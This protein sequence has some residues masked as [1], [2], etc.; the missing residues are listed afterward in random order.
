MFKRLQARATARFEPVVWRH[1]EVALLPHPADVVWS[2]VHPP[3]NATFLTPDCVK[4]WHVEGTPIGLGE[5]QAFEDVHGCVQV[6]EVTEHEP[7]RRA[8]T[9]TIS[10]S[11]ACT[12]NQII[13]LEPR[14]DACVLSITFEY[15]VP[16]TTAL[17]N[18]YQEQVRDH[19]HEY[20][21]R[22]TEAIA[23]WVTSQGTA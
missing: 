3:E 10:P 9:R 2:L 11:L 12:A 21:R 18:G 17:P 5:Q 23:P 8:V 22:V 13:E 20:M 4:G 15:I 14:I 16:P 7:N 19:A 6:I 1:R